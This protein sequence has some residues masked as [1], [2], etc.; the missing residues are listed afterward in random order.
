M[1][2]EMNFGITR[3]LQVKINL[4]YTQNSLRKSPWYTLETRLI[5]MRLIGFWHYSNNEK[6]IEQTWDQKI[7][8]IFKRFYKTLNWKNWP[9][10]GACNYNNGFTWTYYQSDSNFCTMI[11]QKPSHTPPTKLLK[12]IPGYLESNLSLI[13]KNC[14]N[15]I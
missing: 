6:T 4:L 15:L 5:Q 11:W 12:S 13:P 1:I 3:K 2:H 9:L 8:A 10:W 14:T 7:F